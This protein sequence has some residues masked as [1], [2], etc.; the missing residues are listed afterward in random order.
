MRDGQTFVK[1]DYRSTQLCEP[2]TH[3]VF[4]G[5]ITSSRKQFWHMEFRSRPLGFTSNR[6]HH[7]DGRDDEGASRAAEAARP[8]FQASTHCSCSPSQS[9]R[10]AI[11]AH[12]PA[13][14]ESYLHGCRV[15]DSRCAGVSI[16]RCDWPANNDAGPTHIT[17]AISACRGA[18]DTVWNLSS[19][20]TD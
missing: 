2:C 8:L 16:V 7:G 15:L 9:S 4:Q 13:L 12:L 6:A 10:L 17:A 20:S 19:L 11:H 5:R 18:V 14:S 3:L 1:M